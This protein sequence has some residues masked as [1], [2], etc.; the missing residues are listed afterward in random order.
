VRHVKP[1]PV[2]DAE[3]VPFFDETRVPIQVI[4]VPNPQTAGL[5]ADQ[6]EVVSEKVTYRLAQRTPPTIAA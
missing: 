5:S 6:Y 4:R 3:S 2:G 1:D